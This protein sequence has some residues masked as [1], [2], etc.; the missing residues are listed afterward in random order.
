[1]RSIDVSFWNEA[2]KSELD[3]ILS[4][5]TWELVELPMVVNPLVV[6]GSSK[7]S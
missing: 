6:N 1:M 7:R 4:N 3:F 5:Q 2:I